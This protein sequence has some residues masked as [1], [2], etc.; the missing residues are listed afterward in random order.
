MAAFVTL[1]A[2]GLQA[3]RTVDERLIKLAK[4]LRTAWICICG[5]VSCFPMYPMVN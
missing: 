4:E 1:K 2:E 5:G 3:L